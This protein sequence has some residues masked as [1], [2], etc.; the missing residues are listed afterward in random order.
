MAKWVTIKRKKMEKLKAECTRLRHFR[1]EYWQAKRELD[2]AKRSN[3]PYEELLNERVAL[4]AQIETLKA[5]AEKWR[6]LCVYGVGSD[7]QSYEAVRADA[8]LGALVRRIPQG[9]ALHRSIGKT[10]FC[11]Q[12][13]GCE[14]GEPFRQPEDALRAVLKETE[15]TVLGGPGQRDQSL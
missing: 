10:M 13:Q 6:T 15:S 8:E 2:N 5:D 11:I 12:L 14:P 1:L 4:L 7:Q 9:A 3:A